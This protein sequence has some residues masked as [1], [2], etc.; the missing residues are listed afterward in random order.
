[1]LTPQEVSTHAFSKAVMGGYNMAMVD[2]F[3]DELT[4]D[5]TALYKENA[6]LKAKLKVLV[7]KVED[8]RA[9]ED[10]MRATLLTA[11]KMADSI[12]HEAEA[13]RD[14]I[15]AQAESS[16]R[17]KIGQ[18]RQEV[19]T[20][21]ERLRQGQMDL[22]KFIS[23]A[24]EL[25]DRE[26]KFLEQLPTLPVEAEIPPSQPETAETVEQIEEKVM[27]A[28]GEESAE[29][30]ETTAEEEAPAA[31]DDYPEGDPFAADTVDEPT[32]RINLSDLKFGR[33]YSG[34]ED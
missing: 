28:F 1:M 9:T 24:R 3:L 11:Q 22:A 26:L 5:Y 13:K 27:A 6:A 34:G 29:E 4:D 7:E 10:S 33:N 14:E 15:L 18:L 8:Y 25:C 20:A 2:E 31:E 12:V 17:E 21:E 23:A 16:A 19:E 30:E 32:R